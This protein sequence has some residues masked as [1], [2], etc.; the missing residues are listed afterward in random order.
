MSCSISH[1]GQLPVDSIRDKALFL[2]IMQRLYQSLFHLLSTTILHHDLGMR[3]LLLF[4]ERSCL[5][6]HW[7]LWST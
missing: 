5:L 6:L 4:P 3:I 2:N 7:R 1:P